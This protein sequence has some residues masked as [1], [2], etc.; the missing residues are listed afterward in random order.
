MDWGSV[1][2]TSLGVL[3]GAIA[4]W[5]GGAVLGPVFGMLGDRFRGF[6]K[7]LVIVLGGVAGA[8]HL[9]P[10]I[11]PHA[12]PLV[13]KYIEPH[14]PETAEEEPDTRIITTLDEESIPDEAVTSAIEKAMA[15]LQDPFFEAVLAREPGRAQSLN[16]RL[17]SA[18][19]RGGN[20]ALISELLQADQEIIRSAFPHYMARAKEE[21]LLVAVEA[22]S[23]VIRTLGAADPETCH[24]WL[25][26]SMIGQAFDYDKYIAAIGEEKHLF[27]QQRLADVVTGAE[28]ILPEY[29]DDYADQA[30]HAIRAQLTVELGP[31]KVGLILA[32]Q[33][34]ETT[35]DAKL[36]CD[37]SAKYYDL[38]LQDEKAIDI[39]R[40]R[41]LTSI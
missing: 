38:I 41:Y 19:K 10:Y 5:V 27:L 26:G 14:L 39:L 15:D 7:L 25:Y 22:F 37:A 13:A 17:A 40:H 11:A 16:S 1:I 24:L 9:T 2:I 36:A 23:D 34:P 8:M 12:E 33:Q 35:D 3:A 29:D 18:F 6:M 30:L 28:D 31:E 4:G 20:D 32:G 21:D